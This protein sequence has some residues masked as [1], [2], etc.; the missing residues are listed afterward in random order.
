VAL[1]VV[2]RKRVDVEEMEKKKREK[3]TRDP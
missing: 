2:E 3:G 1:C